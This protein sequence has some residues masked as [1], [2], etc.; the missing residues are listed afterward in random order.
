MVTVPV[1]FIVSVNS[2]T[3]RPPG[4][5]LSEDRMYHCWEVPI[6]RKEGGMPPYPGSKVYMRV[7]TG[8]VLGVR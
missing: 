5:A 3:C 1:H 7:D 4:G 2:V 6:I 8:D